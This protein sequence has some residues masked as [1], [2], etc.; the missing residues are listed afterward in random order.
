MRV[1]SD[2]AASLALWRRLRPLWFVE[3]RS[4][5]EEAARPRASSWDQARFA[6][7]LRTERMGRVLLHS[8]R[9]PSTQ[10]VVLALGAG[11]GAAAEEEAREADGLAC[12]ADVQAKGRGRGGN[13]WESPKGCL[14]VSFRCRV[15]NPSRLAFLQYAVSV[16]VAEAAAAA[17]GG[18]AGLRLKWPN[19]LY[20]PCGT[21]KVGGVL[22]QSS[23]AADGAF[24]VTVG[25]GLNVNNREP[26]T[27][28]AELAGGGGPVAREDVLAAFFNAYEGHHARLDAEGFGPLRERYL[29][30]WLHT[31]Q[32]V[33]VDG[34]GEAVI[35][36]LA[37]NGYLL[38]K[39][40]SGREV[41]LHP[42]GNS[43]DF[44]RGL[45]VAKRRA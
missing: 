30:A 44:L 41:E 7:A 21:V 6:A 24:D 45:V 39:D 43:L 35:T 3:A 12:V 14:M 11:G 37:P 8:E 5:V 33:T 28:L 2:S 42:D 10:D 1:L 38:A 29:A 15:R 17:T 16:S 27:C 23:N 13:A 9:L 20:A 22:C 31:G 34:L 19:D 32:R 4:A 36:G 40:D 18:R 25:F 26:T